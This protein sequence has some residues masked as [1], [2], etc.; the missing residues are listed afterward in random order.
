M[1]VT[2]VLHE[3]RR[4]L[5][6]LHL[7]ESKQVITVK[8]KLYL[9]TLIGYILCNCKSPQSLILL[10]GN[11]VVSTTN[12]CPSIP[13]PIGLL[14]VDILVF[15]LPTRKRVSEVPGKAH[16]VPGN[17]RISSLEITPLKQSLNSD[18]NAHR[19]LP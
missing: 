15:S 9:L 4:I 11:N 16:I 3:N 7:V 6:Q 13:A 12:Q 1:I 14:H 2:L 10:D 19:Y 5:S 8:Q 17:Y 18:E